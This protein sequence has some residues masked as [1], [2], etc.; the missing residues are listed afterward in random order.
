[1]LLVDCVGFP[2]ARRMEETRWETKTG[3]NKHAVY[4][5]KNCRKTKLDANRTD[6]SHQVER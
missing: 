1:M 6:T 4:S 2:T 5:N 3:L